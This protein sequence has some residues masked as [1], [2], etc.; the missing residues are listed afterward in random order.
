MMLALSAASGPA[1]PLLTLHLVPAALL[2]RSGALGNY[3]SSRLG[4]AI[5]VWEG[6][7]WA[8]LACLP[9]YDRLDRLVEGGVSRGGAGVGPKHIEEPCCECHAECEASGD[10]NHDWNQSRN[11]SWTQRLER[12]VPETPPETGI[13]T[14]SSGICGSGTGSHAVRDG[15]PR[16]GTGPRGSQATV[17][18]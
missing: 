4:L 17:R 6:V 15:S 7:Y 12:L 11:Q 3:P 2:F 18:S 1:L 9:Y 5:V 14:G 8:T 16:C 13:E 10:W